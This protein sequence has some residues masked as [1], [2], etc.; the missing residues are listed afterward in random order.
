MTEVFPPHKP[1]MGDNPVHVALREAGQSRGKL[2]PVI[3]GEIDALTAWHDGLDVMLPA[4]TC[5]DFDGRAW[6]TPA[7]LWRITTSRSSG[8]GYPEAEIRGPGGSWKFS[9]VDLRHIRSV[10]TV[11]GAIEPETGE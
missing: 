2:N 3:D 9:D 7:G 11:L 4:H 1:W 5:R 10:L 8:Y 6:T